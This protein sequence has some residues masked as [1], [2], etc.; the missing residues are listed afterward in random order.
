MSGV[1]VG[2]GAVIAANSHVVRDVKPYQIVGGNPAI[3]LKERFGDDI[4]DMLLELS[5]WDLP[6]EDIKQITHELCSKPTLEL[7][8]KLLSRYRPKTNC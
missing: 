3:V 1:K 6:L 4:K 5:W 2:S 8:L 7:M